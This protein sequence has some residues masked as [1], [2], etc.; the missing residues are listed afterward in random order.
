MPHSMPKIPNMIFR[1]TPGIIKKLVLPKSF[2][3][4]PVRIDTHIEE[5]FCVAPYYDSMLA[6]VIVHGKTRED[7][8]FS[9][10]KTLAEIHVEG[11]STTLDFHKSIF[12]KKIFLRGVYD[13]SFVGTHFK[14]LAFGT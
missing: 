2:S 11:V 12:V 1:P 5:G 9:N 6:K 13:C 3:S 4:G 10:E 8:G 14:R 7:A